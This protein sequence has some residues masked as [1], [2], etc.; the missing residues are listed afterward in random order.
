MLMTSI[1]GDGMVVRSCDGV[2]EPIWR[3]DRLLQAPVGLYYTMLGPTRQSPYGIGLL[4]IIA[5]VR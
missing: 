2:A 5:R 1:I 4:T 3:T